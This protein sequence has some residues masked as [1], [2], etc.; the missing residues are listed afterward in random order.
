VSTVGLDHVPQIGLRQPKARLGTPSQVPLVDP[1]KKAAK[2][3]S[4]TERDRQHAFAA[5]DRQA[6]DGDQRDHSDVPR[7]HRV[8][9]GAPGQRE[10]ADPVAPMTAEPA[11]EACASH[12]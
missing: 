9:G 6:G 11:A 2:R 4:E 12:A 3:G 1:Q 8:V 5:A 7:M 10:V